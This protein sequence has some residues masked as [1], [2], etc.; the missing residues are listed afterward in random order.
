MAQRRSLKRFKE[1]DVRKTF[2][3]LLAGKMGG[4]LALFGAIL[5]WLD[6][7]ALSRFSA[8]MA[9]HELMMI[10]GAPLLIAGRPVA[11][12]PRPSR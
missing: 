9:Q 8:H 7:A 12:S 4:I 11:N 1:K 5:P 3:L 10:V 2:G 6:A